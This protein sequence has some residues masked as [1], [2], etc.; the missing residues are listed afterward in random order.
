MAI[1]A[2]VSGWTRHQLERVVP[3]ERGKTTR[4]THSSAP[5]ELRIPAGSAAG[6]RPVALGSAG[7]FA[8][9]LMAAMCQR[10][11]RPAH[12]ER[13]R[14]TADLMVETIRMHSIL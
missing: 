6:G 5:G 3:T 1:T 7:T 2:T 14:A 4:A 10:S 9:I 13:A 11:S 8:R 12:R